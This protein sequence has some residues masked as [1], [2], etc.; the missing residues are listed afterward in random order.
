MGEIWRY[1]S[2]NQNK[3][4]ICGNKGKLKHYEENKDETQRIG[5]VCITEPQR[6]YNGT[7]KE[8]YFSMGISGGWKLEDGSSGHDCCL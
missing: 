5:D 2:G 7:P 6:N 1:L 4:G 3:S 8:L